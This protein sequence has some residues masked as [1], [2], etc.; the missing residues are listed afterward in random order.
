MAD[1]FVYNYILKFEMI[2][3]IIHSVGG[4]AQLVRVH[5]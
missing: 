1:F 3:D 2:Y 5:A 4:I